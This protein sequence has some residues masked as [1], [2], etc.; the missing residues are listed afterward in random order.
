MRVLKDPIPKGPR[1]GRIID[2]MVVPLAG[3]F[4]QGRWRAT[5][6]IQECESRKQPRIGKQDAAFPTS[7]WL[8]QRVDDVGRQAFERIGIRHARSLLG[9]ARARSQSD[10]PFRKSVPKRRANRAV[11]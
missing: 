7:Q 9:G 1:L 5:S 4:A 10:N 2:L 11:D 8:I 6:Q 3:G